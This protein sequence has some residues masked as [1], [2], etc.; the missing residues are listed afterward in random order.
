MVEI[1]DSTYANVQRWHID[2]I[3][4]KDERTAGT[5]EHHEEAD[6]PSNSQPPDAAVLEC[7]DVE[8]ED[9]VQPTESATSTSGT[10]RTSRRKAS[11]ID[12]TL[13]MAKICGDPVTSTHAP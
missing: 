1:T 9:A 13:L 5:S 3:Q 6:N 4:L 11:Q 8:Q 7:H 2:Q 12:E 10:L